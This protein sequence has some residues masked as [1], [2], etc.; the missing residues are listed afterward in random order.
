MGFHQQLQV[1]AFFLSGSCLFFCFLSTSVLRDRDLSGW[2]GNMV[3]TPTMF[4]IVLPTPVVPPYRHLITHS[5]I[6]QRIV[7]LCFSHKRKKM[8]PQLNSTK[9]TLVDMPSLHKFVLKNFL[10][11]LL[12][13]AGSPFSLFHKTLLQGRGKVMPYSCHMWAYSWAEVKDV[14][15]KLCPRKNH[16]FPYEIYAEIVQKSD[17]FPKTF[18]Q[19]SYLSFLEITHVQYITSIEWKHFVYEALFYV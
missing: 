5:F 10:S 6:E 7:L 16:F 13:G 18:H 15:R 4:N 2:L 8:I 11:N 14:S 9:I 1:I 17:Y 12:F 19:H 3:W